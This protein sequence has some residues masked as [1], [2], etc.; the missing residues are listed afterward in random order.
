MCKHASDLENADLLRPLAQL[1]CSIPKL[2]LYLLCLMLCS[3]GLSSKQ[4]YLLHLQ[5]I[6]ILA[7]LGTCTAV[8]QAV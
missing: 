8:L 6:S 5:S 4:I 3:M 7:C 1:L 2:I